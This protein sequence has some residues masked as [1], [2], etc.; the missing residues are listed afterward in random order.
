M[1]RRILLIV[2]DSVGVGQAPDAAKYGDANANTIGNTAKA[3]GGL[4][5][6]H[7]AALGLG[8]VTAIAGTSSHEAIHGAYG[9]MIPKSAG[10]DTT[11]GH[12]EFVGVTLTEPLPTY[13]QGFPPDI[14]TPFEQAIGR[15]FDAKLVLSVESTVNKKRVN[16]K[17]RAKSKECFVN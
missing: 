9:Y 10:K 16:K 7:L 2:L 13:P 14:M 8:R 5:I 3:V 11:N 12:Y 15:H 1:S 6:P 4:R 17:K